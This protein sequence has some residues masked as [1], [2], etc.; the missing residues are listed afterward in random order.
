MTASSKN[1]TYLA[2]KHIKKQLIYSFILK[3]F[4]CLLTAIAMSGLNG[5]HIATFFAIISSKMLMMKIF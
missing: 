2:R 5:V 3:N 4:K 1:K